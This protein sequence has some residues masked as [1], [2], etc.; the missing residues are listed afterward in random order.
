[1][2]KNFDRL[3]NKKNRNKINGEYKY[4]KKRRN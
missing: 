3:Y 4:I 2:L 1:M